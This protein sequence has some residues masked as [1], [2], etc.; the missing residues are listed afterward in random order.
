MKG[1]GIRDTSRVLHVSPDPV[2][3]PLKKK[4]ATLTHGNP[5]LLAESVAQKMEPEVEITCEGEMDEH[6]S[7]GK[8]K[9]EQ[10]W[11]WHVLDKATHRILAYVIGPH[12]DA[13]F[14]QRDAL[15]NPFT[16]M[17]DYTDGWAT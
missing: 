5:G 1:S 6:W 8:K 12:P 9:E 3:A 17:H 16:I 14:E 4:E 15:L 10:C 13:V 2:I 11:L 7:S